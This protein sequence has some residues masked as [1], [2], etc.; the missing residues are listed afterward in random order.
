MIDRSIDQVFGFVFTGL[1]L[2]GVLAGTLVYLIRARR[3]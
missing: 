2:A 1:L 3:R